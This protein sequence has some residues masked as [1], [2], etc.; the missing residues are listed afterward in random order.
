M[1]AGRGIQNE[2]KLLAEIVSLLLGWRKLQDGSGD[3]LRLLS[4]AQHPECLRLHQLKEAAVLGW[5]DRSRS[6]SS[7]RLIRFAH[8]QQMLAKEVAR[9]RDT[10]P[11]AFGVLPE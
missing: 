4:T 5:R 1:L 9:G 10:G 6:N 11:I 8:V 3:H 7:K 2:R